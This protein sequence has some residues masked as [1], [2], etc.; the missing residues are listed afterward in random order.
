MNRRA[1]WLIGLAGIA[2]S[3]VAEYL[4]I[5]HHVPENPWL[6][7]L[8]G[9]AFLGA[10][11]LAWS[12]RPRNRTGMLMV[13]FTFSWFLGNL[14]NADSPLLVSIGSSYTALSTAFLAHMVLAYP[15]GRLAS[16]RERIVVAVIYTWTLA[17]ST[18]FMLTF[19]PRSF[20]PSCRACQHGALAPF[21]SHDTNELLETL[22]KSVQVVL[23]LA[24]LSLLLARYA[25][26]SPPARRSLAPLWVA[27]IATAI[28]FLFEGVEGTLSPGSELSDTFTT[29][30][31]SVL[32]TIPIAFVVGLLWN[33]LAESA[34]GELVRTLGGPVPRGGMRAALADALGDP[35]LQLAFAL[36]DAAG[37]VDHEG[38][39]VTLPTPTS[40]R[41]VTRLEANGILLAVLIHDPVL[42]EQGAIVEA[43]TSAA[44]LALENERLNAE[45]RAQLEEVRASRARLVGAADAERRRLER[46]LHD[47]AQQRLIALALAI[48]LTREQAN[49]NPELRDT[50]HQAAREAQ[51][52]LTELRELARGLHPSI[53]SEAGLGAAL[54]S[55]AE[56]ST[57][58][59]SI[60]GACGGRMPD[61]VEAT[62]YFVVSEA[63][64]NAAKHSEGSAVQIRLRLLES[65][66]IVEI[67]DDGVGA[68]DPTR[69][70]GLR[71]LSDRVAAI[72]GT[73]RI[74]S[75][76]GVGTTLTAEMPCESR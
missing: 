50:L 47:G 44:R 16:A 48:S 72:G 23:A 55:L 21:P 5:H 38:A 53:L 66:L 63:L 14:S 11:L 2:V 28:F 6:D 46:D 20:Y 41:G 34:V 43:A 67:T 61:D 22:N 40:G 74:A 60:C 56:R 26:A 4:S 33:R 13:L 29:V 52:A 31:K 30:Q 15:S 39:P 70:S 9:W 59:V 12:R 76:A 8:V 18:A 42:L 68:A 71:G 19:D 24:V 27:A 49:G 51:L 65:H 10:G 58:P 37:Y 1:L 73:L 36:P 32:L 3:I 25:K 54:D 35:S 69:G 17:Q 7:A 45:L 57:L 75:P 64:A 62:A